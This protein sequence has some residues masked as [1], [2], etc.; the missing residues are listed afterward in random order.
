MIAHTGIHENLNTSIWTDC[1]ATAT[2]FENSMVNPHKEKCSHEKFFG[3]IK[4]YA[5]YLLDSVEMGVLRTIATVKST[6]EY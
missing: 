6:L 2:K 1:V 4:D 5:K 3:K